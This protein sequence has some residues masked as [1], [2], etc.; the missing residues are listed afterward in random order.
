MQRATADR[1][2]RWDLWRNH[3]QAKRNLTLIV[4]MDK[5]HRRENVFLYTRS[6]P[7][8][9]FERQNLERPN[10]RT[11]GSSGYKNDHLLPLLP[12]RSELLN[13]RTTSSQT[14]WL[15]FL[16]I[17]SRETCRREQGSR[18]HNPLPVSSAK[19]PLLQPSRKLF[20]QRRRLRISSSLGHL[21]C[22]KLVGA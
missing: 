15:F 16:L 7:L 12:Q 20:H 10:E 22:I 8:Q 9:N 17:F 4:Q 1:P 13:A 21:I 11:N 5:R 2:D 14:N 6:L 18:E 19:P 3:A